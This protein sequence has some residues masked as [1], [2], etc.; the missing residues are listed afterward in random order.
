MQQ[1]IADRFVLERVVGAGGMGEVF[2]ATDR[3]TGEPVAVKMMYGGLTRDAERFKREAQLLA[4]ISHPRIVRYVAHGLT[5][6]GRPWLAMEWLEGEDLERRLERGALPWRDVRVLG[7]RIASALAHAHAAGA[8][9]RDLSTCNVFLPAGR[10]ED[11]KL[12]DFGLVRVEDGLGQTAGHVAL[13]TPYYMAPEQVRSAKDVDA[14]ADL[15]SLGAILYEALA[16][17]RPFQGDDVFVLWVKIME[18]EAPDLR[19]LAPDVPEGFVRL[20]E[21]L[22]RKDPAERPASASEVE[23]ALFALLLD[24]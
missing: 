23:R 8:V 10:V 1:V 2:R 9:H 21:S 15:F 14:R 12:V 16:G 13:G 11:A 5:D 18:D 22:M 19:A 4:E 3:L 17:V 7:M 24:V 6:G 20:V